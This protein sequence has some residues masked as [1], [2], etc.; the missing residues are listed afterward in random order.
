MPKHS[1]RI[2]ILATLV[3]GVALTL[4][5]AVAGYAI[6]QPVE[7]ISIESK[8]PKGIHMKNKVVFKPGLNKDTWYMR[9]GLEDDSSPE[10]LLAI[11]VEDKSATFFQLDPK[12]S[13]IKTGKL[14]PVP[15]RA[16]CMSCHSNG[17]RALRPK[18]IIATGTQRPLKQLA[19]LLLNLRVKLY[20][21]LK[22]K[23][24]ADDSV[25]VA[26]FHPLKKSQVTALKLSSCTKCHAA[27]GIR[28]PLSNQQWWTARHLVSTGAMPPWPYKISKQD[29]TALLGS[30]DYTQK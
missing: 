24:Y 15:Y 9:Q 11:V 5:T 2:A 18:Q 19:V 10:D 25:T 20:G 21:P 17:P 4:A 28:A 30:D 1:L 14:V 29:K 3:L 13:D 27:G 7:F 8:D 6:M 16:S 22:N 12:K 23:P 26:S